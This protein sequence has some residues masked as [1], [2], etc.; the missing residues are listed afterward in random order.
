MRIAGLAL[1]FVAVV[2]GAVGAQGDARKLPEVARGRVAP[3]VSG[4]WWTIAHNPDLGELQ[5][6]KQEPVDFAI[7]QAKDGTWQLWSC[8]RHTGCGGKTRLFHR[9]E[10]RRLTSRDWKPMGVAMQ[11]DP[12]FG[13]TPGGLQ[14][15][16][17]LRVGN[18][19]YMVYGDWQRI[20]LMQ[21]S[22]GKHFERVLDERG[23]PDLFSGPYQNTRDAMLMRHGELFYCYYTGHEPDN[24]R[25]AAVFCRTSA[26]LRRWSEPIVVS[27]GGAASKL[28][29]PAVNCEC[30]FVVEHDG[31]FVLFRNLYYGA[32]ATNVQYAS[33][34]PL[35]FGVDDDDDYVGYLRVAAPEIIVH[36][37][38]HY[39][40]ALLPGLDGIRVA[41]LRWTKT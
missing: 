30:P 25:D 18:T 5:G 12:A 13:E 20:C 4:S 36:K 37:G 35:C 17:V 41:R 28:G 15:P 39:I 7:W 34:N 10:G 6:P 24:A 38:D 19:F 22:D 32:V 27:A 8:I 14:A 3:T 29:S 31:T 9:W 23:Q 21:S 16:H 26:D 33:K 40:A 2:T 11:A 1:S